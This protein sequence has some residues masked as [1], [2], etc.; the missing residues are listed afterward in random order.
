MKTKLTDFDKDERGTEQA[1][2]N[3][4]MQRITKE[5]FGTLSMAELITYKDVLKKLYQTITYEVNGV[6]YYSSKYDQACIASAVRK[7]FC[8]KRSF[9]TKEENIPQKASLLNI[10]NFTSTVYKEQTA[11]YYPDQGVVERIILDDQG[12][13][14]IDKKEKQLMELAELVGQTDVLNILQKKNSSHPQKNRSFHYLPYRTDSGFEQTFLQE[15]LT[16]PE[17][18][19]MGLLATLIS[20]WYTSNKL[21]WV[22]YA[23]S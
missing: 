3:T 22:L 18:E 7:A 21:I 15:V 14:K 23:V 5:S 2:F 10:A 12:K 6:R 19:S 13:L 20:S 17:I 11:N 4:W 1:T 8:D 9:V 16:F